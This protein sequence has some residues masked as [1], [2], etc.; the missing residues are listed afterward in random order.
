[1]GSTLDNLAPWSCFE[2]PGLPETWFPSGLC[3][4][5]GQLSTT[6]KHWGM[7]LSMNALSVTVSHFSKF[8]RTPVVAWFSASEYLMLGF[9]G[10]MNQLCNEILAQM[11]CRTAAPSPTLTQ[12]IH[13]THRK[14]RF[15]QRRC[16][17]VIF[18]G[19]GGRKRTRYWFEHVGLRHE[20]VL[21]C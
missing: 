13:T 16:G 19:L 18:T 1:M 5:A 21:R 3:F 4:F 6:C 14:A 20:L 12:S 7:L 8:W 17:A 2:L 10:S 15:L 9:L 11:L